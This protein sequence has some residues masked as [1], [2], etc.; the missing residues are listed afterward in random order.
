M[1]LVKPIPVREYHNLPVIRPMAIA[2]RPTAASAL[3][4]DMELVPLFKNVRLDI[5]Q[6]IKAYQTA[7]QREVRAGHLHLTAV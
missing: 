4:L 2:G 5:Q 7:V 3:G 6:H 1:V